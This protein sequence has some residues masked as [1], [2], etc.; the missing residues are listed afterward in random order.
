VQHI[1]NKSCGIPRETYPGNSNRVNEQKK[2]SK[3]TTAVNEE[4][5][6]RDNLAAR[7]RLVRETLEREM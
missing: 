6:R 7:E 3:H 2:S 4:Q 1:T 5:K